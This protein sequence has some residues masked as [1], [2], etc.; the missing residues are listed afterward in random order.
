MSNAFCKALRASTRTYYRKIPFDIASTRVK[1]IVV[2][3]FS[4][5]YILLHMADTFWFVSNSLSIEFEWRRS[6]SDAWVRLRIRQIN[7]F[8]WKIH[9]DTWNWVQNLTQTKNLY[10]SGEK[11]ST[12]GCFKLFS[13]AWE[14]I[15]VA[16]RLKTLSMDSEMYKQLNWSTCTQHVVRGYDNRSLSSFFSFL[17]FISYRNENK[18][19]FYESVAAE[20]CANKEQNSLNMYRCPCLL[21]Y[22][23]IWKAR[24]NILL[25]N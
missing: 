8:R 2:P 20:R 25:S 3:L 6:T 9:R 19:I 12:I 7:E 16:L 10:R 5:G 23:M 21:V 24:Y 4:H 15:H 13:R 14:L 11:R 1:F 17:L 18:S 22:D